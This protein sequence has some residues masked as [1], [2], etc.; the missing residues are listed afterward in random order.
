MVEIFPPVRGLGVDTLHPLATSSTEGLAAPTGQFTAG[1]LG[2]SESDLERSVRLEGGDL[3]TRGQG[4]EVFQAEVDT[5]RADRNGR[6]GV[7]H[8]AGEV[9]VPTAAGILGERT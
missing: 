9:E 3:F 4:G 6:F 5:N 8:V 7:R 2:R 1:S